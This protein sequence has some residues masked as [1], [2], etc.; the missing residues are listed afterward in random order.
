MLNGGTAMRGLKSAVA[1]CGLCLLAVQ[2]AAAEDLTIV[3][4]IVI[5]KPFLVG[6]KPGTLTLWM[7]STKVKQS[8]GYRDWI[9]DVATGTRI[10]I[11][12]QKRVYWE[13]TEA[14]RAAQLQEWNRQFTAR[15][16]KEDAEYRQRRAKQDEEL[17]RLEAKAERERE[18]WPKAKEEL[19]KE[20][21][22]L[23]PQQQDAIRQKMSELL[24]DSKKKIDEA[25]SKLD[26]ELT[27]LPPALR[28]DTGIPI[29]PRPVAYSTVVE[30]GSSRKA[31]AGQDCEQYLVWSTGTFADGTK[32]TELAQEVWVA[33][34]LEVPV[35]LEV[36]KLVPFLVGTHMMKGV[37]LGWIDP[38]ESGSFH[39]SV[40]ATEVRKAP[41]DPSLFTVPAGYARVDRFITAIGSY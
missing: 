5:P 35:S 1:L 17:A 37:P 22:R 41:I 18:Q 19:E 25:R 20:W 32:R 21:S 2:P 3:S 39:I 29:P 6:P 28:G 31:I 24:A 36:L 40:L 38:T 12:H 9:Y 4:E 16:E 27:K 8:D 11:D 34:K 13:G 33:P 7:S 15:I 26:E 10:D 23:T 30:K 14:E